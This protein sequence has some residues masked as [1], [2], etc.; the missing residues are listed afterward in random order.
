MSKS[1]NKQK[2]IEEIL[3]QEYF[4]TMDRADKILFVLRNFGPQGFTSLLGF[5]K[6]SKSTLSKYITLH[7]QN[8]FIEKKIF[9][10]KSERPRQKYVLTDLGQKKALE[11]FEAF[12][13]DLILIN[14]I[15][16]SIFKL[17]Q[18]IK[19]YKDISVDEL[20]IK[21]IIRIIS[22]LGDRFFTL[23][24]NEN[25]FKSLFFMFLN[26]AA[27]T[28]QFKFE[29][30]EFCKLYDVKRVRIEY[31]IDKIMSS[32]L[33]FF[34]FERGDDVF[35]FHSE[36]I[37]GTNTL[38][39]IKDRL[40][41]E[42]IHFNIEG[43]MKIINLDILAEKT[44]ES[45]LNMGLIWEKIKTEFEILIEK[46]FIKMAL[47][48]GF[49]KIDLIDLILNSRK[50][51]ENNL[52]IDSLIKIFNGSEDYEDLNLLQNKMDSNEKIKNISAINLEG[53]LGFCS[54]CGQIIIS[55]MAQCPKCQR[56]INKDNLI[57]DINKVLELKTPK[58]IE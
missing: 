2:I 43:K 35:F 17:S 23:E 4:K 14:K 42:L 33:G 41:E 47:D 40:I 50:F 28:P 21:Y 52:P 16:Q 44:A 31:Y 11:L 37:L 5:V 3:N 13:D 49:P 25:L 46:I 20:Y 12:D 36:D 56:R 30:K 45:L 1:N 39:I 10:L 24:Q 51:K 18:L 55:N 34:M 53:A 32:D 19:F 48:M 29:I 22:K 9:S 7:S 27:L 26:S 8:E 6:M 38:R 15:N 58:E 54:T 57:K